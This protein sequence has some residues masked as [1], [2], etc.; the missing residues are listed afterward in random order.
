MSLHYHGNAVMQNIVSPAQRT[1]VKQR[2][3][4]QTWRQQMGDERKALLVATRRGRLL[5]QRLV[6]QLSASRVHRL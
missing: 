1:A 4:Q 2:P 6:S 3:H 5:L